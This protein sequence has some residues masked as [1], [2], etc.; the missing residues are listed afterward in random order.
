MVESKL[1]MVQGLD[2]DSECNLTLDVKKQLIVVKNSIA[3]MMIAQAV[4][5]ELIAGETRKDIVAKARAKIAEQKLAC[6]DTGKLLLVTGVH[7]TTV[8]VAGKGKKMKAVSK[9]PA[10]EGAPVC[11][12]PKGSRPHAS[13]QAS[14][15]LVPRQ[16]NTSKASQ[17]KS[18]SIW[19]PAGLVPLP[20]ASAASGASSSSHVGSV[21]HAASE[22]P[23]TTMNPPVKRKKRLLD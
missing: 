22:K 15:E 20:P 14:T 5:K 4:G 9:H 10:P 7:E 6:S 23:A 8:A 19:I 18:T 11:F 12:K 13:A 21:V 16:S 17:A 1:Y 3:D 2:F